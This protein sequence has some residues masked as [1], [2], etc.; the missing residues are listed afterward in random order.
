MKRALLATLTCCA[1]SDWESLRAT[2]ECRQ[3][4]ACRDGGNAG[5]TAGGAA[6]GTAGGAA[7]GAAGGTAGGAAGGT[8]G[9]AAGGTAGGAAGG[10]AGG[11]A[12]AGPLTR[13]GALSDRLAAVDFD[14][15][16]QVDL[17]YTDGVTPTVYLWR[18]L[19]NGTFNPMPVVDA[20]SSGHWRL[21]PMNVA[22]DSA[23]DLVLFAPDAGDAPR[24]LEGLGDLTFKAGLFPIA[25]S[26]G[27]IE[28]AVPL[29]FNVDGRV[30]LVLAQRGAA[31]AWLDLYAGLPDGGFAYTNTLANYAATICTDH[32]F[33]AI[34]SVPVDGGT[35]VVHAAGT[36]NVRHS[37]VGPDGGASGGG[38][39][40]GE[41]T[42]LR[43]VDVDGDGRTDFV[44]RNSTSFSAL[45][46][47]F[48]PSSLFGLRVGTNG[49]AP[50]VPAGGVLDVTAG[51]FRYTADAGHPFNLVTVEP[52]MAQWWPGLGYSSSNFGY[53][54][55]P[56]IP[57][58]VASA[59]AA[60]Q[61]DANADGFNDLILV[62]GTP[63]AVTV[64][65]GVP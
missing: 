28:L 10:T 12:D 57:L 53:C 23:M 11:T 55:D 36:V 37:T 19:G 24:V 16:G 61:V 2:A 46:Q 3:D 51:T 63:P 1:C 35:F 41:A 49:A 32:C 15:D 13:P 20:G 31:S 9:G 25:P 26:S 8:A 42:L 60:V 54:F 33:D 39:G 29:D 50:S 47:P 38:F 6:G 58:G 62:G 14:D 34:R 17:A 27:E 44:W 52:G 30:D 5:G 56:A 45:L 22:G 7:G 4:A 18:G 59:Q 43:A 64:V 65:S 40:G 48:D 21:V